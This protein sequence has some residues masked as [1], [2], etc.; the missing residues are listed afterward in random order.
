MFLYGVCSGGGTVVFSD[1]RS[2]DLRLEVPCDG[3]LSRSQIYNDAGEP[4]NLAATGPARP[5]RFMLTTSDQ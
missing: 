2:P 4:L 3:V 5:W 1:D